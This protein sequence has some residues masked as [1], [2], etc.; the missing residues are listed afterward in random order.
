MEGY[1]NYSASDII[2]ILIFGGLYFLF[3]Y[4]SAIAVYISGL[5]EVKQNQTT[6]STVIIEAIAIQFLSVLVIFIIVFILDLQSKV[7][8]MSS[9]N[10]S[11]AC[12]SFFAIDWSNLKI[13]EI[14][15]SY[16]TLNKRTEELGVFIVIK[17]LWSV[18]NV[19]F[20]FAPIGVMM[21]MLQSVLIKHKDNKSGG[22]FEIFTDFFTTFIAVIIIFSI[23]L[24]IPFIILDNMYKMNKKSILEKAGNAKIIGLRYNERAGEYIRHSLVQVYKK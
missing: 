18:L 15:D 4:V 24:T 16:I 7:A 6:I 19:L 5:K 20:V 14:L 2:T 22:L 17:G 11:E 12:A 8:G 9:I 21:M 23:H 3:G 1:L 10:F 13:K